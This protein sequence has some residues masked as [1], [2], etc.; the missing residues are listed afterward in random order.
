MGCPAFCLDCLRGYLKVKET[1]MKFR[2]LFVTAAVVSLF[3]VKA[4]QGFA[5]IAVSD[6][7]D[8][9]NEFSDDMTGALPFMAP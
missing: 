2:R 7:T 6:I 4:T 8:N 9:L 5:Q 1:I 3:F